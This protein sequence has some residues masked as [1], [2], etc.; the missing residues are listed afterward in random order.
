MWSTKTKKRL[1]ALN[2]LSE[3]V[4]RAGLLGFASPFGPLLTQ[5]C[6]TSFDSN[7]RQVLIPH[8]F[9]AEYKNKK[10]PLGAYCFI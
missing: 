8:E 10:T 4:G 6:L 7:L 9:Y 1:S 3:M 5:R 2:V